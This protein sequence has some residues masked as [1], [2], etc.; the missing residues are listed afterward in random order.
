L[1][2]SVYMQSHKDLLPSHQGTMLQQQMQ[3]SG[4]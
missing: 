3:T 2:H 1:V 4:R